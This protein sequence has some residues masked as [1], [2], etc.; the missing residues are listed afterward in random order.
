[1][2]DFELK[3]DK[4]LKEV[5]N[6]CHEFA[7]KTDLD[8]YVFQTP[9]SYNPDLLII[10]IN[11]GGDKSYCQLLNDKGYSKRPYNDLGYNE[12]T[13][14]IKPDWEIE[15]QLKGNDIMRNA[16]KRVFNKENNLAILENTIMMNMFYFN[17][18]KEIHI[19]KIDI[20]DEIKNY[21]INKTK[22][23]IE[24]LN[25]K[26]VLFLTSNNKNLKSCSVQ[27]IEVLG[28]NIKKGLLGKREIYA[29]PHYGS[30]S[31][32]SYVNAE[33]TGKNLSEIFLK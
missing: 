23:F 8:F 3:K 20:K 11:P 10:G 19:D 26:N 16:F 4:W 27:N 6:Q 9:V 28:N 22:E 25:P 18:Q 29:I 2:N 1:M 14:V 21:C 12:N 5:S 32:Y 31:A 33:K 17:T 24:I 15:N 30:Y 7:L 13:L